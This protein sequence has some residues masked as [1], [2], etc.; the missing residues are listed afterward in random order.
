MTMQPENVTD[1]A[2]E[3]TANRRDRDSRLTTLQP[4]TPPTALEPDGVTD[5]VPAGTAAGAVPESMTGDIP[6]SGELPGGVTGAVPGSVSADMDDGPLLDSAASLREDWLR[7]QSEFVDNPRASVE[8][9]AGIVTELTETLVTAIQR[10][11]QRLRASWEE[12]DASDTELLRTAF[13]RYRAFFDQ[14]TEV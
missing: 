7:I 9:A 4:Q 6:G 12:G 13:R 10:R 1:P 2:G 5:D 8:E 11:E 3:E 14:L